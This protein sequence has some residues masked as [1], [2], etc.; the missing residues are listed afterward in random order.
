MLKLAKKLLGIAETDNSQDMVL[1]FLITDVQQ[2]ILDH[3]FLDVLPVQLETLVVKKVMELFKNQ[4]EGDQVKSVK[5]GDVTTEF[6]V[7]G[8]SPQDIITDLAPRL[9]RYRQHRS[10]F[11]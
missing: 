5:R 8:N 2:A 7:T 1:E 6:A 11:I 3:C 10:R 9:E 4:Q